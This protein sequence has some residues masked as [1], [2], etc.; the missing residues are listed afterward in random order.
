MTLGRQP[1]PVMVSQRTA[2]WQVSVI[3]R[4]IKSSTGPSARVI[5]KLTF[6]DGRCSHSC[7]SS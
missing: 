2:A 7:G 6:C 3:E 4:L 5:S 1:P